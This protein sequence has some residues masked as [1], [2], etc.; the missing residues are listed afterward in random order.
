MK[1]IIALLICAIL[2]VS[3]LASCAGN[4]DIEENSSAEEQISAD[5]SADTS[6]EEPQGAQARIKELDL[7]LKNE[8]PA[9]FEKR[10]IASG[11][12]YTYTREPHKSWQDKGGALTDDD[13]CDADSE[14]WVGFIGKK[15]NIEVILDLG[16]LKTDLCG[17]SLNVLHNEYTGRNVPKKCEFWVSEDGE[18][19]VLL[20]ISERYPA[21]FS[22]QFV[23]THAYYSQKTF[24]ASHVKV[25]LTD[26]ISLWTYIDNLCVYDVHGKAYDPNESDSYYIN[27]PMPEVVAPTYWPESD[28]WDTETNLI[29]GLGQ[30]IYSYADISE[31]LATA[32]YNTPADSTLLTN[33][34]RAG[35]D[36]SDNE[37]FHVTRA[38]GRRFVYDLGNVSALTR[39]TVGLFTRDTAG[40]STPDAIKV[41]VSADGKDW[42]TVAK[43][44]SSEY[45]RFSQSR[46][47]ISFD[48]NGIY[49]ARF[50]RFDL[51]VST[52]VWLDEF[53]AYGTKKIPDNEKDVV[54][55][56][57]EV[58]VDCYNDPADIGGSENIL[59]AYTFIPNS[60]AGHVTKEKY[61]PYVAYVDTEGNILDTFFDSYLF[62][63]CVRQLSSGA[64]LF[65]SSAV[66]AVMNDW[67]DYQ[68]DVFWENANVNA[69]EQ[70]A[71]EVKTALG[72]DTEKLKVFF[73]ILNPNRKAVSF[74][75]VDGD[76]VSENMQKIEDRKKVVKWWID[77]YIERFNA[78]GYENLELNGFYWYDE[79]VGLNDNLVK[80]TLAFAA[81]YVHQ[82]G[83]YLIWIPYHQANGYAQWKEFGFDA[84]NMQPNYMFNA[85]Q[86]V[87]VVYTNAELARRNGMG[88]EIEMDGTALRDPEF[89]KRYIEYLKIGVETGYMNAV[90][91][92]YQDGCPGLLLHCAYETGANRYLYDITYKYAKRTLTLDGTEITGNEITM[93]KDTVYSGELVSDGQLCSKC[94]IV[95]HPLYGVASASSDGSIRYTPIEGFTGTDCFDLEVQTG[96]APVRVRVKV[97]V[98]D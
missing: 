46:G 53:E 12:S 63:P 95:M 64:Y 69:L 56:P 83:Y 91:M 58:Y 68:N 77:S 28:G 45:P 73:T 25:V 35:S 84:A 66:P 7:L 79:S 96:L 32:Y 17:A 81:D 54:P 43:L 18:N 19:Y 44:D 78:G 94:E 8:L 21:V 14:N 41:L 89:R 85:N 15:E 42:Q 40:I 30:R 71:E 75:D 37:Y 90:K 4:D 10:N 62:L 24:S 72:G 11:C 13:V 82:L 57:E 48:F 23:Y 55:D 87:Q 3:A 98:T 52:H 34:R 29:K 9:D 60:D 50:V 2:L 92:Y 97:T 26:F 93:Q 1:R 70:T 16:G 51:D 86:T 61:L 6:S 76:G 88:V 74:G 31:D 49:K 80:E 33:G 47:E 27:D 65:S 38:S 22:G 67:L 59:L 36:Y 20:G 39:A 5:E